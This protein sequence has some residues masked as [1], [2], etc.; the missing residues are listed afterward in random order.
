MELLDEIGNIPIPFHWNKLIEA[1]GK[2]LERNYETTFG[3]C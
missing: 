1:T 2:A 3:R